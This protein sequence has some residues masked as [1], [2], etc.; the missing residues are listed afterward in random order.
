MADFRLRI[1]FAKTGLAVWLSHLEIV[2]AMERCVRRSGLP[3]AVSQGFSPHMKHT[4]SAALPVGTGSLGEYMDLIL[5][6]AVKPEQ[7]LKQL[8]AVQCEDL[9]VLSTSYIFKDEPSL[10]VAYNHALYRIELEDEDASIVAELIK[11]IKSKPVIEI[12]KK[13]KPKSYD[14]RKYV[15]EVETKNEAAFLSLS[16]FQ[17]SSPTILLGLL[18]R[19]EGSIRPELILSTLA[20][21]DLSPNIKALTRVKIEQGKL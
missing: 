18:N 2:R 21:P 5:E 10:Q 7:A 11:R 6:S 1:G 17:V 14:L 15:R 3:Y 19:P 12:I 16:S 20:K 4:F 13:G 8:Q 9:P